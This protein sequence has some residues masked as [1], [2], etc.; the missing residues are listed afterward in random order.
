[1]GTVSKSQH[2]VVY[3]ELQWI[4][5][6]VCVASAAH[7][8]FPTERLFFEDITEILTY[9]IQQLTQICPLI[10]VLCVN[11]ILIAKLTFSLSNISSLCEDL[12]PLVKVCLCNIGWSDLCRF[13][14]YDVFNEKGQLGI[15]LNNYVS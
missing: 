1:M 13:Q 14:F 6:A 9:S 5:N 12:Y 2:S 11:I 15:I 8:K 4:N 7:I 3:S 10:F